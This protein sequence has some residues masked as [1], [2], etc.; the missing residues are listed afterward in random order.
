MGRYSWSDRRTVE[1]CRTLSI[2]RLVSD[3]IVTHP[4]LSDSPGPQRLSWSSGFEVFAQYRE[5][6]KGAGQLRLVYTFREERIEDHVEVTSIPSPLGHGG[7]RY[8]FKCHGIDGPCGRRVGKLYRPPGE[9]Y[10]SCRICHD[11]TYRACKEHDKRLDAFRRLPPDALARA[12]ESP[13]VNTKLLAFRAAIRML[14]M[15]NG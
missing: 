11:L 8:F 10:F 15:E 13:D 6:G 4:S 3:R 5:T 2:A 7:R 9:I 12:L 14:G 1:G